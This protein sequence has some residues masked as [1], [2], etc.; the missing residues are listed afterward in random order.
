[1]FHKREDAMCSSKYV[2]FFTGRV[3]K[4][5]FFADGMTDANEKAQDIAR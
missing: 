4:E 1:M 2:A 5:E 3:P